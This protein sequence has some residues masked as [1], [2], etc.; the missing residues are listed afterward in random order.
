MKLIIPI[1]NYCSIEV[2][3]CIYETGFYVTDVYRSSSYNDDKFLSLLDLYLIENY[4]VMLHYICGD[5]NINYHSICA[6]EQTFV[7][8]YFKKNSL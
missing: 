7:A 2:V 1:H 8:I 5:F 3:L 6:F 4:K